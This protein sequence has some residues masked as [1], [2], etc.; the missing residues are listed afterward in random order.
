MPIDVHEGK[1]VFDRN[2]F[3]ILESFISPDEVVDITDHLD[4]YIKKT[5]PTLS[6][7]EVLYEDKNAPAT[8]FR[9]ENM[10]KHDSYFNAILTSPRFM[11]MAALYLEDEIDVG[12]ME[13]FAKAP[14][15]GTPTPPHQ[16]G[17]YFMRNPPVA[18]TFWIAIDRADEDNGCLCYVKGSQRMAMRPH[19]M[20][21]TLGFS[22]GIIDYNEQDT[23]LEA[24][25]VIN[26]GDVIAHHCMV[27]HRTGANRTDRP[28]RALGC[29]YFGKSA[30]LD[31]EGQ[32]AYRK[33]LFD[34]WEKEG[35]I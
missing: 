31:V 1:S 14:R 9:L 26:P 29:I 18:M 28:R 11:E 25:A 33:V 23:T 32:T 24:K 6:A 22:Q 8:L 15:I 5:V 3:A 17:Y 34:K 35:K 20:S 21:N 13:L 27:V 10:G 7:N 2:G 16:D 4:E 30:K 19:N 12:G